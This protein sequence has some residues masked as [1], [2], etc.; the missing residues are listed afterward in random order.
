MEKNDDEIEI[1]LGEVFQILLEN[2]WLIISAAM[3]TALAA[4]FLAK[5]VVTPEYESTTKIYI[6]NKEETG[7]SAVTYSDLQVG[8]S[9]TKD[10]A[11]LVKSRFVMEEVIQKLGL[12]MT[13]DQ[14]I[15]KVSID[16]PTD[17]RI[18]SISVKDKDPVLAMHIANAVRETAAVHITNVMDIKAVNVVETANLPM[19]KSGPSIV[20]WGAI[21]GLIG[22]FLTAAVILLNFL[23][24]DTIKTSDDIEKHLQLSTLALIPMEESAEDK[25]KRF[26]K[27]DNKEA[28][29]MKGRANAAGKA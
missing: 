13:Y 2:I 17:T 10:Y 14:L 6:L 4:V 29:N 18:L 8:T 11:E 27:K 9:L 23:L 12:D 16:T 15:K 19:E 22:F 21:G 5:F 1:D 7:S 20:K 28:R 25:K 26:R 24:D 3:F